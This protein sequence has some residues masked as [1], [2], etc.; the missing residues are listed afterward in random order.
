MDRFTGTSNNLKT[1]P[2]LNIACFTEERGHHNAV[3]LSGARDKKT[4]HGPVFWKALLD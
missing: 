4:G 2:N 1:T 3:I